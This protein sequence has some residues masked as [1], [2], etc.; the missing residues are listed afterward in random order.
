MVSDLRDNLF[1]NVG[2][3]MILNVRSVMAAAMKAKAAAMKAKAA[4][5]GREAAME[6]MMAIQTDEG[7]GSRPC[8]GR[9][10]EGR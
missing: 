7:Q 5:P 10:H 9:S 3:P 4:P 8:H 6:T 2:L 1:E